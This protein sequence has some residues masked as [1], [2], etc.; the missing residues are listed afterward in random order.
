MLD[1]RG[2]SSTLAIGRI[3]PGTGFMVILYENDIFPLSS[4][5]KFFDQEDWGRGLGVE[6]GRFGTEVEV[7]ANIFH[8]LKA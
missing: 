6:N 1:Y 4:L 8:Q 5:I 3:L 2:H 7:E